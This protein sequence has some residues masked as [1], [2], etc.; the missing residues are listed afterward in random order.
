MYGTFSIYKIVNTENENIYIGSTC[1]SLSRRMALHRDDA[2][3]KK[4]KK[5]TI[6]MNSIGID[7]FKICLIKKYSNITKRD[8]R[9][10]EQEQI[11]LIE[12]KD[13]I[14]NTIRAYSYNHDA[15]RCQE[16]KR[17]TRRDYYHRNK[18]NTEWIEKQRR[19]R[20]VGARLYRARLKMFGG[21]F[22]IT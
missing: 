15:T 2:R 10:Y 6:H 20:K 9:I 18:Q 1:Q 14:L 16:T 5:I 22:M 17:K 11:N 12:E 13:K 3:K 7:K 21:D 19:K 4:Q 8:A